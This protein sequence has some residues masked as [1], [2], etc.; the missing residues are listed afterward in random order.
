VKKKTFYTILGLV[1]GII[2]SWDILCMRVIEMSKAGV[3]LWTGLA[4]GLFVILLEGLAMIIMLTTY[5]EHRK[6]TPD[7]AVSWKLLKDKVNY[8]TIGLA[9]G[10]IIASTNI[11]WARP[12]DLSQAGVALWIF[13]GVGLLIVLLQLIPAVI[14]FLSFIAATAKKDHSKEEEKTVPAEKEEVKK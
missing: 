2:L 11:L 1:A 13:L 7:A 4:M 9:F 8:T 10:L 12:I 14:M 5:L 6:T 3:S